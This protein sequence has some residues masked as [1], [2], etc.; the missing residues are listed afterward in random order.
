VIVLAALGL[1]DLRRV[2]A[3]RRRLW[4]GTAGAIAAVLGAALSARSVVHTF[5]SKPQLGAFFHASATWGVLTVAAVAAVA[6]VRKARLRAA[7]LTLVVAVDAIVLFAVPEFSAPRATTVDLAPVTYLRRHIGEARFFTLGPIQP[8]YGSYFGLASLG[9][10]DFP[11]KSYSRYVHSR[12]DPVTSFIGFRPTG[13]PS[14][15]QELKR[16]LGGYRSAGVRY[17]LTPAG[18]PLPEGPTSLRLVF[19]SPSTRIYR[20]AGAAPYF[21]APGCG[22]M[23]TSRD[24]ARVVCRRLTTLVRR[25]TWFAGWKARLDGHPAAIRRADGL[26]QAVTV[27]AGSHRV[28]FSFTP[29]GMEWAGL[30]FLAGCA[31]MLAPAG[32]R[33]FARHARPCPPGSPASS[34]E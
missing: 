24:S 3:N 12:L 10:D 6:L 5:G 16:H 11:P 9:V 28:T 30:G 33:L 17:V 4:W 7:L 8:D 31:L 34:T 27:R 1:D 23:S 14:A 18:R 32:R 19:R 20:L 22:V 13:R 25:E 26:F 15:E 2:S 21:S 29:P